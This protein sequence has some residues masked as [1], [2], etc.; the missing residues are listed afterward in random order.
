MRSA[1]SLFRFPKE[2]RMPMTPIIDDLRGEGL[3]RTYRPAILLLIGIGVS[4]GIV[5]CHRDDGDSAAKATQPAAGTV[6]HLGYQKIGPPFLLKAR[7]EVLDARLASMGARAE[8]IEFQA[9]PPIFEAIAGGAVDI[10]YVGETPPIFAQAGGVDFVYLASDPPAPKAEAILVHADSP[11]K[12]VA[13][14]R[15]KRVALNRGSNVHYL[16]VQAL[17]RA[18]LTPQDLE[19]VFLAPADG[20]SAFESRQVDAWVIWDPFLADAE[21]A[22]AR[23][24]QNGE[25]LVDNRI[26]YVARREL[27]EKQ[28]DLVR[29]VLAEYRT[30][31]DWEAHH[32]EEAAKILEG[33]SKIKYDPLLVTE[34]RHPYGIEAITPEILASQQTIADSFKGL[35]ILPR[36][37]RVADAVLPRAESVS[38]P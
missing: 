24:L 28:P 7:S 16:L 6:L 31:S 23:V 33:S 13:D 26:Y 30:L 35:G 27:A 17:K 2:Q 32:A 36:A 5:A 34:R 11:L 12:T 15:G 9:G 18:G 29:A 14:L 21:I 8:W 4:I 25:G 38:A 1:G 22:G 10:G 20:R 19:I 3:L 37:I